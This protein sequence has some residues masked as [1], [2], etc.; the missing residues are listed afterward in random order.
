[1]LLAG[2]AGCNGRDEAEAPV[3]LLWTEAGIAQLPGPALRAAAFETCPNGH[4]DLRDVPIVYGLLTPDPELQRQL[5]N[6]EIIAGGCNLRPLESY[7]VCF[8][9]D[10]RFDAYFREWERCSE[11]RLSFK[12]RLGKLIDTFPEFQDATPAY[13]QALNEDGQVTKTSVW[14]RTPEGFGS[15]AKRV[16]QHVATDSDSAEKQTEGLLWT[17]RTDLKGRCTEGTFEVEIVHPGDSDETFVCLQIH[18]QP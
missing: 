4:T 11:D 1:M 17:R 15:A 7:V 6:R 14:F 2:L 8:E 18:H 9:C 10:F 3:V 5:D 13:R 16:E 12:R